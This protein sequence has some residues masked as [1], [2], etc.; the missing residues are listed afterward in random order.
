MVSRIV[1]DSL[2]K[3]QS[4]QGLDGEFWRQELAEEGD[5]LNGTCCDKDFAQGGTAR[6]HHPPL[7]PLPAPQRGARPR[8]HA[9]GTGVPRRRRL[10]GLARNRGT[11][12][13]SFARLVAINKP[14]IKAGS[15]PGRR[16]CWIL[17][18]RLGAR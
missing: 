1:L 12:P 18:N 7:R 17:S 9:G 16:P 13:N 8:Q 10:R 11:L 14:A 2:S 15:L 5:Y 4:W 3:G 6:R